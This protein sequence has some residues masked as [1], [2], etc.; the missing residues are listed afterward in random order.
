[1][2]LLSVCCGSVVALHVHGVYTYRNEG[3]DIY[4]EHRTPTT[5]RSALRVDIAQ[6]LA[7]Y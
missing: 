3:D 5:A 7:N 1:M 2:A 4:V 6:Y